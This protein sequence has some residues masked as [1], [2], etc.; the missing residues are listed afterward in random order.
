MLEAAWETHATVVANARTA[1]DLVQALKNLIYGAKID[2][3][4]PA[5]VVYARDTRPSGP[6]LVAAFEDGLR[7][8]GADGRNEGVKTTPV[9]HYLVRCI[10]SKGTKDEYG[11]DSEE[12]YM[13][14]LSEAF[15]KLV[16]SRM[17]SLRPFLPD[18][19]YPQGRET[20]PGASDHRLR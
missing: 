6:A 20:T 8:I 1:D 9:L 3:Q 16:V 10:N 2:L 14:K 11:V 4:K 15:K 18:V 12:G 7:A 13:T 19:Y 5:R 17:I